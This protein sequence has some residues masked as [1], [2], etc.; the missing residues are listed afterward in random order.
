VFS[1]VTDT[2]ANLS[3]AFLRAH[4]VMAI[5][6]S[7][8]IGEQGYQ[9]PNSE[10]FDGNG[11]YSMLREQKVTTSLI[12]VQ[13]Y[14]D[15]FTPILE[16]G[17]NLLYI[18]MS[19]GI[20]GA[21]QSATLAAEMLQE[22]HSE[23]KILIFDTLA[24][25]LG[26]G[27]MVMEAVQLRDAGYSIEAVM[28][29]LLEKRAKICQ[30]FT[31]DDLMY[32]KRGGRVHSLSAV[33][34]TVLNI[35]PILKGNDDGRI[36]LCGKARGRKKSL[37]MLADHLIEEISG[38]NQ[39]ICIA[40]ANCPEDADLLT[41]FIQERYHPKEVVVECYEPVT[42]SHVGPGAIALFFEGKRR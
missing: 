34:G 40:H 27:L 42:G 4:Q 16:Q 9:C 35:K 12:N 29:M 14:M 1:I 17:K 28:Q 8:F 41:A 33:F 19:S 3:A 30:Y 24:A 18:G 36:V 31:V 11:F 2:S 32:L 20:S 5:P 26:E 6:F 21:L 15:Y 23:Q 22:Q 39:T 10:E 25:S 7:Y 37:R 38:E 13:C